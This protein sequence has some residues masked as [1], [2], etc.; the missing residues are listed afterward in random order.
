MADLET[1]IGF[2]TWSAKGTSPCDPAPGPRIVLAAV[3]GRAWTAWPIIILFT[4]RNAMQGPK[5]PRVGRSA[6]S[7]SAPHIQNLR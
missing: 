2:C 6:S 4:L 7:N 3:A 5:L 1:S